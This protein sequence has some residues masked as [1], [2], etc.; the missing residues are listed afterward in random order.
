MLGCL[1]AFAPIPFHSAT[2]LF[3][4]RQ[5]KMCIRLGS[6][7]E[8]EHGK[9]LIYAHIL[10]VLHVDLLCIL[11]SNFVVPQSVIVAC[12]LVVCTLVLVAHSSSARRYPS[13]F[14]AILF[15]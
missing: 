4:S 12:L 11:L 8:K 6:T 1:I 3:L 10:N 13:D 9:S 14:F 5:A 15:I 7:L 2:F